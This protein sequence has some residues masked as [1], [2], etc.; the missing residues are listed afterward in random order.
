M[1]GCE[2]GYGTIGG[3]S[4]DGG[5]GGRGGVTVVGAVMLTATPGRKR[6]RSELRVEVSENESSSVEDSVEPDSMI[7]LVAE[8]EVCVVPVTLTP[9]VA[10]PEL[11]S[12]LTVLLELPLAAWS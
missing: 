8:R 12:D 4:G 6:F 9:W 11:S 1:G 7:W 2:G 10:K 5:G 3:Y